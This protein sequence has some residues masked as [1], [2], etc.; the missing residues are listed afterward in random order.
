MTANV[1]DDA[2]AERRML[3]CADEVVVVADHSKLGRQ[4]LAFLCE[5]SA[6]DTLIV[7]NGITAEQ[8]RLVEDAGA[9]Q[10]TPDSVGRSKPPRRVPL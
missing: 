1:D 2:F 8:R 4:N 9:G 10:S 3:R 6:I 5:L 7:D